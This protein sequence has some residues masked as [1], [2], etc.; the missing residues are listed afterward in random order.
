MDK[1]GSLPSDPTQP[2]SIV[3]SEEFCTRDSVTELTGC[4]RFI[5]ASDNENESGGSSVVHGHVMDKSYNVR[6]ISD[7]ENN[8]SFADGVANSE[9]IGS[10]AVP[11]RRGRGPGIEK[12]FPHMHASDSQNI[13]GHHKLINRAPEQR[14][15]GP[16]INNLIKSAELMNDSNRVP[17]AATPK[18]RCRGPGVDKMYAR[19]MIKL[20]R[21]MIF[22]RLSSYSMHGAHMSPNNT[23]QEDFDADEENES[24]E[25]QILSIRR[26]A[27]LSMKTTFKFTNTPKSI[28]NLDAD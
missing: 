22:F 20:V 23:V 4:K 15:R 7:K 16:S 5:R 11:R 27:R 8:P 12:I 18:R 10:T 25:D 24:E 19:T 13:S 21:K 1:P 3:N 26:S 17:Q 28:V 14:G 6:T 2:S 9:V